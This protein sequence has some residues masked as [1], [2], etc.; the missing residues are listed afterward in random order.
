MTTCRICSRPLT[1]L[2]SIKR[3]IGPVCAAHQDQES[4]SAERE[5]SDAYDDATPFRQAFVMR[6]IL[7]ENGHSRVETNIPH[8]VV[9]HS[10]NG[11]E[12][13]YGGSGPADLALNACQLYLTIVGYRGRTTQCWRGYCYTLA[14]MLHQDFKRD[15]IESVPRRGAIHSFDALDAWFQARMTPAVLARYVEEQE[16]V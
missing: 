5:F 8:L 4:A 7:S 13:G 3:G 14:W 12:F 6:R 1:D 10:P 16:L 11:F 15:F 9:H 2:D